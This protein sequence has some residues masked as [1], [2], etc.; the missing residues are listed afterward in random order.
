MRRRRNIKNK[1]ELLL[2]QKQCED[3][4]KR[5]DQL[6][7]RM[8]LRPILLATAVGGA[9]TV[10]MVVA[11]LSYLAFMIPLCVILAIPGFLCWGLA[12]FVY[13]EYLKKQQYSKIRY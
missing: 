6:E 4:F 10:F 9:G 1:E 12:R 2:L 5:I 11:V 7:R 8:I 13:F 3:A